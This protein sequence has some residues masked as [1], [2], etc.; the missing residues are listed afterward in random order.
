MGGGGGPDK[1]LAGKIA[2]L[3]QMA[4][5]Q[6][7]D[8]LIAI[9]GG[10]NPTTFPVARDMGA[11]MIVSGSATFKAGFSVADNLRNLVGE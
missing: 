8:P 11:D 5:E 9:D 2:D 6:D 7:V 4:N 3:R 1:A 10:I